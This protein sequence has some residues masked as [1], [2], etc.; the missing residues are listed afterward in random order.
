MSSPTPEPLGPLGPPSWSR[1]GLCLLAVVGL[2]VLD[3][4]SKSAAFE[5]L[6]E[7]SLMRDD[8]GHDRYPLVGNWLGMMRNLN[9]GAAFGQLKGI[10]T[11][12]VALRSVAIVVLG[13]LVFRAPRRKALYLS[14]LVLILAGAMGNLYD[15][16]FHRPFDHEAGRP[17][18]P[19]RDFIDV[20]F[21]GLRWHFPTFNVAD[22]CITVG[23]VLLLLSGLVARKE[24]EGPEP[25]P[26]VDMGTDTEGAEC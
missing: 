19:V 21:S 20:Y 15:N 10:P 25:A 16:L 22:S 5:F 17:F 4:W 18:G 11:A 2:V 6:A 26:E 13:V 12:L 9:Y 7:A 8:T 1:Q 14:A 23:A 3:L 24:E